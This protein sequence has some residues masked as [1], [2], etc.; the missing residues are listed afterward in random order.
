MKFETFSQI[1]TNR[2]SDRVV[3][4]APTAKA[5][6]DIGCVATKIGVYGFVELK[7]GKN[8]TA[9]EV[10]SAQDSVESEVLNVY[11]R[12]AL[13]VIDIAAEEARARLITQG[14]IKSKVY[15]IQREEAISYLDEIAAGNTPNPVRYPRIISRATRLSMTN[16]EVSNEWLARYA[17]WLDIISQIDDDIVTVGRTA[18]ATATNR[19]D[20]NKVRD[21]TILKLI[22]IKPA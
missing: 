14:D 10:K 9:K 11:R 3:R 12:Q 22:E 4:C 18:I 13:D 8:L 16:K 7:S 1:I 17:D 15:D 19:E 2:F 6:E 5:I 21:I 20:I